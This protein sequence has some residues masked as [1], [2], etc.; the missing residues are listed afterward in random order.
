[1]KKIKLKTNFF[2]CALIILLS[3]LI[4][5]LPNLETSTAK[6]DSVHSEQPQS[7]S[8]DDGIS[9]EQSET[10]KA[11]SVLL[12]LEE[13][14]K[15]MGDE[16]IE[17]E[18]AFISL[19]DSV[20]SEV[21]TSVV[22]ELY[23]HIA[24]Y[25]DMLTVTTDMNERLK[26]QNLIDSTEQ[27]IAEYESSEIASISSEGADITRRRPFAVSIAIIWF[28][29]HDYRL[30]SEL[31]THMA[32]NT[33]RNS[34]YSPIHGYR[35]MASD[36]TY[37]LIL[38]EN[39]PEYP[40]Y[41]MDGTTYGDDLR[42]AIQGIKNYSVNGRVLHID[43][44]YDFAHDSD[45]KGPEQIFI[46]WIASL[47]DKGEL[48]PFN[49]SIDFDAGKYFRVQ[50]LGRNDE[51]NGWKIKI[52]NYGVSTEYA[53]YNKYMCFEDDAKDWKGLSDVK[54]IAI[55]AGRSVEVTIYENIFATHITVGQIS[56]ANLYITYADRLS[57]SG[58][59]YTYLGKVQRKNYTKHGISANIVKKIGSTWLINITNNTGSTQNLYY[60]RK[61][62]YFDDAKKWNGLEDIS[63][64]SLKNGESCPIK[65]EENWWAT[66]IAISYIDGDYRKIFYADNLADNCT[67]NSYSNEK[68]VTQD[69]KD[70]FKVE[71]N[72]NTCTI[73]GV[74]SGIRLTGPLIIPEYINGKTVTDIGS[75]AFSK[76]TS[77]TSVTIP[78][79][80]TSIGEQ[81]FKGCSGLER[82]ILYGQ[83]NIVALGDRAFA[84]TSDKLKIYVAD[85]L[86]DT[87]KD[88]TN[89][90]GY[91]NKIE[92]LSQM[93]IL[94]KHEYIYVVCLYGDSWYDDLF[95][96]EE[97][98]FIGMNM[99]MI[100]AYGYV[101]IGDI[102]S[103]YYIELSYVQEVFLYVPIDEQN[104]TASG[105]S[106]YDTDWNYVD[107]CEI[108]NE[109]LYIPLTELLT[110]GRIEFNLVLEEDDGLI[111][112]LSNEI[113]IVLIVTV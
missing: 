77:L 110:D 80:V 81:A 83:N 1:M 30:S 33:D 57:V 29:L 11:T 37:N 98:I 27:L 65:I 69:E 59:V 17:D 41:K 96:S 26:I 5:L 97:D 109:K 104:T 95:Y 94:F 31:I 25:E 3:I 73:T 101:E 58:G 86:Y 66:S 71:E 40:I 7:V 108:S 63:C 18:F 106:L 112:F 85:S 4:F 19:F 39:V 100:H 52:S 54:Y 42:Y 48:I 78:A 22:A 15:D 87:Y 107:W 23:N 51:G 62:C 9:E 99:R 56:G 61:M 72:D 10:D 102:L 8:D 93:N 46:N 36:L 92:K 2:I 38:G 24:E 55:P 82:V 84:D 50:N 16:L 14:L 90:S 44:V 88:A 76:C 34:V 32:G 49:V 6:A 20:L 28:D 111:A 79:N 47:Q 105:C 68:S 43:D 74:K 91:A 64:L 89:W 35:V 103:D 113:Y 12:I 67:M 53:F 75:S 60:N 45:S 70:L 21:G 13:K